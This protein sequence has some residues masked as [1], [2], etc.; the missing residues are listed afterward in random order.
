M[1]SV[2]AMMIAVSGASVWVEAAGSGPAIVFLHAGVADSRMWDAEFKAFQS[3]NRVVRL[4]LRGFGK[5]QLVAERFSYHGDV[6]AVMDSLGIERATLV[7]CSFG[8][9]VA[10]DVALAAPSR[11]ERLVMISPSIGDGGDSPDI[12]AFGEREEAALG[13]GDLDA[14]TEENLRM[15]VDGPHRT[16]DQV[17]QDVRRLV[18]AMQRLAFEN[19]TPE[20]VKL[21]RLVPP[22]RARLKEV[23]ARTLV[24]AGSAD[25]AHVLGVAGRVT[26]GI[27]GARLEIIEGTAHLPTLEEPAKWQALL[28]EFLA[29]K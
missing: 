15:W 6:L 12:R 24:V 11:A 7:G 27:P 4:D 1:E 5:T 2:V 9:N 18:G 16:P 29:A 20:G 19:P 8:S 13:R 10:L 21:D 14:A 26:E 28:R 23:K 25:V 3:T 17:N 22:A